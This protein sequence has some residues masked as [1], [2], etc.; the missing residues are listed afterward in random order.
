MFKDIYVI[1]N[2]VND[3][4]YVGQSVDYKTRFRKHKEE[5]KR[6]NY[7]YKSPL[8]DS[9]NEFGTDKFYVEI[10]E[11]DVENS[12]EREIYWIEKL[13]TLWPNGYNLISGGTRYPNLSGILHHDAKIKSEDDLLSIYDDLIKTNLS[14]T[15][16]GHK[17]GVRYNV[18]AGINQGNSYRL[19][20]YQY[21]L[22]DFV[23]NKGKLDR[24][25]FDLK[26]STYT[27]DELSGIYELS[28]NQIKAINY[29]ASQYRDYISYPIRRILFSG[30]REKD[31]VDNIQKDLI[32]TDLSFEDIATKYNCSKVTVRRINIGESYNNPNYHY[33]L[34]KSSYRLSQESINQI[35][36]KLLLTNESIN[37]IANEYSVSDATIKRINNG[38]TKK[39]YDEKY[40]YPLRKM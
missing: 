30:N 17:Y 31:N 6:K 8:Y 22:R 5:A 20:G 12:N 16:I 7:T 13:N 25:T 15:D 21:P 4:C 33:P 18:I 39:Y 9:M 34:R 28:K 11:H 40:I 3:M 27:Y 14:L 10:L 2:S 38:E 29:G 26:Y 1:R 23:I 32:S 19:P 35:H 36:E 37:D 24:L